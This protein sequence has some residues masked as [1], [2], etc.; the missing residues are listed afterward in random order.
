M[1]PPSSLGEHFLHSAIATFHAQKSMADAAIRQLDDH[2]LHRPLDENTNSV[3][4]IIKH[5][6]GNMLSRWTDF[7]KTDGEKPSRNRDSEFIDDIPTRDALM[8]HWERGWKCLFTAL[9]ALRP[10]D[11]TERVTIRGHPHTVVQAIHRQLDHYGYHVGQIVHLARF[12]AKDQWTTLTI[13]RGQSAAYNR[14]T[15]M[16]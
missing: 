4:I 3:A 9:A 16:K 10:A 6:A 2:Q 7:L 5:L 15:W 13:P 1:N 14:R 8:A 11:L 12:L